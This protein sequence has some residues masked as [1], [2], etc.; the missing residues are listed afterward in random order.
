M[1]CGQI[2]TFEDATQRWALGNRDR[3]FSPF[4]YNLW[5]IQ[6]IDLE[7]DQ[8]INQLGKKILVAT[9]VKLNVCVNW[10]HAATLSFLAHPALD[11]LCTEQSLASRIEFWDYTTAAHLV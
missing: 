8:Q 1:G 6:L 9:V 2:K 5:T 10:F 4:S 7:N 3:H 11:L